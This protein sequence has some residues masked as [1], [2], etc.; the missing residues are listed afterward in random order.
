MAATGLVRSTPGSGSSTSG[1]PVPPAMIIVGFDHHSPAAAALGFAADLA[2]ALRAGLRVVHVL[3]V[4]DAYPDP[5]ADHWEELTMQR[6]RE[7]QTTAEDIM[8]GRGCPW[9]Y[10]TR[11]GAVARELLA[12]AREI[13]ATM[14]VLGTARAGHAAALAHLVDRPVLPHLLHQHLTVPILL[15]PEGVPSRTPGGVPT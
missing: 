14:L 9:S 4:F 8:A 13:D 11:K 5:D 6:A 15:V 7:V 10:D 3:D 12:A 1:P 2:T